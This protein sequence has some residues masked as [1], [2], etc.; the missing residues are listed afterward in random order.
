M[1]TTAPQPVTATDEERDT[2]AALADLLAQGRS[3]EAQLI[4]PDGAPILLPASVV[5]VLAQAIPALAEGNAVTVLPVR[6]ELTTQEAA[7]LLNVSR[8]YLV[9]LLDQVAIPHSQTGTHRRVRFGDVLAYKRRRDV[10]R[11]ERLRQLTRLSEA[12]GMDEDD[13]CEPTPRP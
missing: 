8:Q 11:R 9:R 2:L 5:R 7:D 4:G 13:F 1:A 12:L 6:R 10:A 3:V